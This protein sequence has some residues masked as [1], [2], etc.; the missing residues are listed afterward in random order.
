MTFPLGVRPFWGLQ[1]LKRCVSCK[2]C[3]IL[4]EVVAD[5]LSVLQSLELVMFHPLSLELL[6]GDKLSFK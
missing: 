6:V 5:V 1:G 3:M 2:F 4:L